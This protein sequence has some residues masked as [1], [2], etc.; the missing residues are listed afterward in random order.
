MVA[1]AEYGV[2]NILNVV[3]LLD[4]I[5]LFYSNL[6]KLSTLSASAFHTFFGYDTFLLKGRF[7][8]YH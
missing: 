4:F 8:T 3:Y 6:F 7:H 2:L 5:Y 1:T